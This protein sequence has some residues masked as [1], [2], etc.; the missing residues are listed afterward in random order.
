[1]DIRRG[2]VEANPAA[3]LPD[4]AMSLNNLGAGL[5]DVGRWVEALAV[6]RGSQRNRPQPVRGQSS[7]LTAKPSRRC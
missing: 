1:M 2:L 5:S 4:L 7:H 3:Y 6:N